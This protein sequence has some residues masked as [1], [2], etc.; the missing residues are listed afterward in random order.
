MKESTRHLK[1]RVRR[2]PAALANSGTDAVINDVYELRLQGAKQSAAGAR[3]DGW[4]VYNGVE[5]ARCSGVVSEREQTLRWQRFNTTR[6]QS[7]LEDVKSPMCAHL[8]STNVLC[9]AWRR[10]SDCR[11][12][13]P[14]VVGSRGSATASCD[15]FECFLGTSSCDSGFCG[16]VALALRAVAYSY[17]GYQLINNTAAGYSLTEVLLSVS[18]QRTNALRSSSVL[19]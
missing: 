10:K 7:V 14:A 18:T 6:A 8:S 16:I 5:D 19:T 11:S 3:R 9:G 4:A 15:R 1:I 2:H 12:S 13:A 17:E